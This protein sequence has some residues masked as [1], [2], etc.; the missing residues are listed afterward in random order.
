[1]QHSFSKTFRDFFLFVYLYL[2]QIGDMRFI[3]NVHIYCGFTKIVIYITVFLYVSIILT[4]SQ[5]TCHWQLYTSNIL[6]SKR[7][8]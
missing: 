4:L 2:Q 7:R 3:S 6:L 8:Y 1:M 5:T